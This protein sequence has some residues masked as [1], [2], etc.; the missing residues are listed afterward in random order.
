[1]DESRQST[2]LGALL[3]RCRTAR[4]LSQLELALR[5]GVST[6][7]LSFVE[8]GRA[9]PS[10]AM[11]ERLA[12]V[13]EATAAQRA[14]IVAAAAPAPSLADRLFAAAQ[15]IE[16]ASDAGEVVAAARPALARLGMTQFFFGTIRRRGFEPEDHGAFPAAWLQ[17]YARED[18]AATDP[19]VGAAVSH[20]GCFYWEDV[21]DGSAL[22]APAR[23]M[24]DEAAAGGID[25]GFVASARVGDGVRLVS[26]MGR[27]AV[28]RDPAQRV[29]LQMLGRQMIDR[30]ERIEAM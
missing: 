4:G 18:Y 24:F 30:L 8:T 3:R 5:A 10:P 2:E 14:A 12:T 6:R 1:M 19:L 9:A 23:R 17:R 26:M 25:T 13:L 29:G 20:G 16:A 27:R 15:G 11:L 21:V 7:H 28:W 22:P